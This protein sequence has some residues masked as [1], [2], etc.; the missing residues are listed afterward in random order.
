MIALASMTEDEHHEVRDGKKKSGSNFTLQSGHVYLKST[1]SESCLLV[2]LGWHHGLVKTGLD[3]VC[4]GYSEAEDAG[5]QNF[6]VEA[7]FFCVPF[8]EGT[9]RLQHVIVSGDFFVLD[10]VADGTGVPCE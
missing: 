6:V 9:F 8:F 7:L 2:D 3:D 5:P 4:K 1:P 10:A